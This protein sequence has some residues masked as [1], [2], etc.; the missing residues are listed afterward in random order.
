MCARLVRT[1][2]RQHGCFF[3]W[4]NSAPNSCRTPPI[5]SKRVSGVRIHSA[6][7][8]SLSVQRFLGEVLNC[9]PIPR[10]F[11]D[12]KGP[13]KAAMEPCDP[14]FALL[15]L[16]G[17]LPVPFGGPVLALTIPRSRITRQLAF[18]ARAFLPPHWYAARAI[19]C[20]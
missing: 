20:T 13:E 9:P 8:T 5:Q 3:A 14:D 19:A 4:S 16:S 10:R 12:L 7:P 6:P 11:S 17:I 2:S 18:E 15:S 1:N